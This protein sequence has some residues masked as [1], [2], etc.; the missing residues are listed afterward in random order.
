[1]E[2]KEEGEDLFLKGIQGSPKQNVLV[3]LMLRRLATRRMI[4]VY[5]S[6]LDRGSE[7]TRGTAAA[8]DMGHLLGAPDGP[9]C[10]KKC[11][12]HKKK[13]AKLSGHWHGA[14]GLAHVLKVPVRQ[15]AQYTVTCSPTVTPR[16][17]TSLLFWC[18]VSRW[19]VLCVLCSECFFVWCMCL[20]RGNGYLLMQYSGHL[21]AQ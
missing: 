15:N 8:P 14:F 11:P 10:K 3:D 20:C 21:H 9:C 13:I 16:I 18:G 2:E 19:C 1:M 4:D 6:V 17:L 5:S 12:P 7:G